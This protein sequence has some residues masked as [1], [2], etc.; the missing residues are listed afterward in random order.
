MRTRLLETDSL[1]NGILGFVRVF[2]PARGRLLPCHQRGTSILSGIQRRQT[3]TPDRIA[4]AQLTKSRLLLTPRQLR[5]TTVL[6]RLIRN[7]PTSVSWPRLPQLLF[8]LIREVYPE[9]EQYGDLSYG[10][11]FSN[12]LMCRS[13]S[14]QNLVLQSWIHWA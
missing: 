14:F 3:S 4:C 2:C 1:V 6:Q 11:S 8:I 12:F 13:Y 7:N 5:A 10:F 9:F